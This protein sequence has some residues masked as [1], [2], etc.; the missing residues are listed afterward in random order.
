MPARASLPPIFITLFAAAC[1]SGGGNGTT[2]PDTICTA[3]EARCFANYLGTCGESGKKW[4]LISCGASQY[5]DQGAC[6]TR[7]C[8]PPGKGSCTDDA[9]AAR[10]NDNGSFKDTIPCEDGLKCYAGAC[11]S[12]TCNAGV[13]RCEYDTLVTCT[14]G[15]WKVEPCPDEKVCKDDACV[16]RAC[17][18]EEARCATDS[19]AILCNITGTEWIQTPC[20][21]DEECQSGFCF[22]RV[23]NPP[24]EP[25][26]DAVQLEDTWGKLELPDMSGKEILEEM[27][28]QEIYVPGQNKATINGTEVKFL[29]M[30]DSNWI[31][32]DQMLMINLIS[33]SMDG[34]PFPDVEDAKHNIEIRLK[35][36]VEGQLGEFACED[37][38]TY[39][40]QLWYRYGKYPQGD[41]DCKN[42]D[43][44][45]TACAVVIEEFGVPFGKIVGTFDNVQLEDCKGDGTTV[46]ITGGMFD[47]ER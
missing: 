44:Q 46:Q 32:A 11:L 38:S 21:P 41:E 31:S 30:H 18:P 17:T 24:V 2:L 45:G 36:I 47:V 10:C 29:Q 1:S 5:C 14:G 6:R 20:K 33:K 27:P 26:P 42:Y 4:D 16:D 34:V 43:Y 12:Q 39:T 37:P 40:V 35:G 25:V 15:G 9:T 28:K 3:G 7:A 19:V 8:A 22:P 23:A 13:T